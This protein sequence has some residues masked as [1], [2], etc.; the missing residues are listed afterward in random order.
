[1]NSAQLPLFPSLPLRTVIMLLIE[2]S[3]SVR[4]CAIV[5]VSGVGGIDRCRNM[6][7]CVKNN[8]HLFPRHAHTQILNMHTHQ[9][10]RYTT[11]TSR[12][13]CTISDRKTYQQKSLAP[14]TISLSVTG[15]KHTHKHRRAHTHTRDLLLL[16]LGNVGHWPITAQSSVQWCHGVCWPAGRTGKEER[17]SKCLKQFKESI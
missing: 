17:M 8:N 9:E 6:R 4:V 7:V 14:F 5:V 3:L 15:V 10:K 2:R 16:L 12:Q 13:K 11:F 1:M